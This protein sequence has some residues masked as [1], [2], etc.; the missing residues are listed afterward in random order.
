MEYIHKVKPELFDLTGDPGELKNLS[1]IHPEV[2]ERLRAE[3]LALIEEAPEQ[4]SGARTAIDP[5]TAA[6]L[7][8]LAHDVPAHVR[9][10]R[11]QRDILDAGEG[12]EIPGEGKPQ[13]QGCSG[14]RRP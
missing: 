1:S 9:P 8:A 7:E 11:H 4:A 13:Q 2:V 10:P 14:V 6:Q 3:L 5:E 12:T